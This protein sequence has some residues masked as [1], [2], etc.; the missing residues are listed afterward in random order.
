MASVLSIYEIKWQ[1]SH[2]KV[3]LTFRPFLKDWSKF[4]TCLLPNNDAYVTSPECGVLA[5]LI[6][7]C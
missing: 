3:C 1:A 4:D 6:L 2:V 5:K 7:E